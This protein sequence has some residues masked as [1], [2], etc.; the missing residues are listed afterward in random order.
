MVFLQQ[1]LPLPQYMI[2][3]D[4]RLTSPGEEHS[5]GN[6]RGGDGY[7]ERCTTRRRA[8]GCDPETQQQRATNCSVSVEVLIKAAKVRPM[9]SHFRNLGSIAY[10]HIKDPSNESAYIHHRVLNAHNVSQSTLC[11]VTSLPQ[12]ADTT[13]HASCATYCVWLVL[14]KIQ[15]VAVQQPAHDQH[16]TVSK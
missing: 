10:P 14:V 9:S 3:C 6:M 2:A 13:I 11:S 7:N 8:P 1:D 5:A 16:M 12:Q 4:A 15:Q